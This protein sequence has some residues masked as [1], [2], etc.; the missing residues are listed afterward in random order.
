MPPPAGRATVATAE[1]RKG[2]PIRETLRSLSPYLWPEGRWDL[3]QR[4]IWA[5]VALVIAKVFTLAFPLLFGAAVDALDPKNRV[6]QAFIVGTALIV[7]YGV[8][9]IMMQAFNQLRDAIAAK[10]VYHT[11]RQV[12]GRTFRHIHALS[13]RFH[14]ERKTGGLTRVI[15]R[16]TRAIDVLLFYALFSI[17]PTIL[18]LLLISAYLL[19]AY[20]WGFAAITIV[21]VVIYGW[22]TIRVTEWRTEIRR[23]MNDSDTDANTKAVDSL[24]NYETVKYFNNEQHEANRFDGAMVRF[25]NASEK[26]QMSL[27]ILNTGQAAIIAVG[28]M[29]VMILAATFI[30]SG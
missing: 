16:G 6:E 9:R 22:F 12:A 2:V 25:A 11:V 21:T 19:W 20:H 30:A 29:L 5:L 3:K 18:E 17:F 8:A 26:S 24:L 15:E 27:S 14:L 1:K 10:V 7:A 23:Q 28:L 13:L 4:I